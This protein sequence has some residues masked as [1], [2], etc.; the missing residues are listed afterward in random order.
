L[1]AW[2]HEEALITADIDLGNV[3]RRREVPLVKEVRLALLARELNR[4]A[5]EGGDL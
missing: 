5:E 1:A 2:V 4:L 3:C